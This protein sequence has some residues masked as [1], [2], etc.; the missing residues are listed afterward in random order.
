MPTQTVLEVVLSWQAFSSQVTITSTSAIPA[1]SLKLES[2]YKFKRVIQLSEMPKEKS[3]TRC[4]LALFMA[5]TQ[6]IELS[7]ESDYIDV[8]LSGWPEESLPHYFSWFKKSRDWREKNAEQYQSFLHNLHALILQLASPKAVNLKA[9][10]VNG[11]TTVFSAIDNLSVANKNNNHNDNQQNVFDNLHIMVHQ[12]YQQHLKKHDELDRH[13]KKQKKSHA[14]N[15]SE[16]FGKSDFPQPVLFYK[17]YHKRELEYYA[18]NLF[19]DASVRPLEK[20]TC[21]AGYIQAN[22]NSNSNSDSEQL[23]NYREALD[24]EAFRDNNLAEIYALRQGLMI[25]QQM[26]ITHLK[27]FTDSM[28]AVEHIRFQPSRKTQ[29][30]NED[31]KAMIA[32]IRNLLLIF[33]N[34]EIEH[35]HRNYNSVADEMTH[36]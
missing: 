12:I 28:F 9:R 23:V 11:L 21:I 10:L 7:D 5:L 35:V 34:Y 16:K 36:F 2:E 22:C 31:F 1:T 29:T 3:D 27:I 14:K 19:C 15:K 13:E 6:V 4:S 18:Y 30:L 25:A 17:K 26:H 8:Q 33:E 32:D 20:R 24:Y